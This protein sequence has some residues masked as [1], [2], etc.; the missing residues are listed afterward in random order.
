MQTKVI[1]IEGSWW[2]GYVFMVV[3]SVYSWLTPVFS[4]KIEVWQ[5]HAQHYVYGTASG[6]LLE[7][8][9][10]YWILWAISPLLPHLL[11]GVAQ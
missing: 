11:V 4:G 5:Y 7:Q 8:F 1:E 2:L 6:A 10:I 3:G 9:L